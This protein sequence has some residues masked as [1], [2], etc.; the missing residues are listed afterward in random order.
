MHCLTSHIQY[1]LPSIVGTLDC[2]FRYQVV[3][4]HDLGDPFYDTQAGQSQTFKFFDVSSLQGYLLPIR[5]ASRFH[6]SLSLSH[7]N[8]KNTLT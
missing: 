1:L 4:G 2:G 3:I 8:H 6:Q 7:T 5:H